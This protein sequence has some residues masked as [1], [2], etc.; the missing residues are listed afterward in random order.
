MITELLPEFRTTSKSQK[1][2]LFIGIPS[3]LA[4][5]GAVVYLG[6]HHEPF[7]RKL[8]HLPSVRDHF[9][10]NVCFTAALSSL[11]MGLL[12]GLR[13]SRFSFLISQSEKICLV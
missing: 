2:Q 10:L 12:A 3:L 13:R 6:V 11:I 5:E 4:F 9:I 1:T 7:L 8:G